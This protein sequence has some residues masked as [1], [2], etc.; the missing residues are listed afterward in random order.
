[1]RDAVAGLLLVGLAL[2][3]LVEASTMPLGTWSEPGPGAFPLLLGWSL[4]LG[5][6]FLAARGL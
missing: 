5:A 4:A 3:Y 2:V 1:M 6:T